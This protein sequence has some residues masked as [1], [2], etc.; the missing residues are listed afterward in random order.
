AERPSPA[1]HLPAGS[2][3]FVPRRRGAPRADLGWW[4]FIEGASFRHPEGPASDLAGRADHPVVHV[5]YRDA[6][7]YAKWANKALPTEAEWERAA[8]GGLDG[9]AYVWGDELAPG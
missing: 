4:Q 5:A 3:V 1:E 8:R 6:A 2:A 7:A 9:K